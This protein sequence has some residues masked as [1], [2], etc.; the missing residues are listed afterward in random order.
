MMF[1]SLLVYCL[2]LPI[3]PADGS[4]T[5]GSGWKWFS[6]S[7][8][9]IQ[10]Y[11]PDG[12]EYPTSAHLTYGWYIGLEARPFVSGPSLAGDLQVPIAPFDADA[13]WEESSVR[14]SFDIPLARF[15]PDGVLG[16]VSHRSVLY[17]PSIQA[18]VSIPFSGA[19]PIV[20]DL[21]G[22]WLKIDFGDL[23]VSVG[24]LSL[25]F[26]QTGGGALWPQ[27]AG[28]GFSPL[29]IIYRNW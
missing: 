10:G 29:R 24:D 5:D 11:H 21:Q 20:M 13:V 22:T 27:F 2:A 1:C 12:S 17:V 6:G 23:A 14:I 16:T 19:R 25:Q 18:G 3:L 7:K 4:G 9:G 28:W 15:R 26:I 8:L